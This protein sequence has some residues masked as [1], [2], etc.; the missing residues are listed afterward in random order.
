MSINVYEI[1]GFVYGCYKKGR[2]LWCYWCYVNSIC[3][4]RYIF[5]SWWCP[6]S[7]LGAA[8]K[9]CDV[10]L[11]S[12]KSMNR[13]FLD[14]LPWSCFFRAPSC[15]SSRDWIIE[16]ALKWINEDISDQRTSL[17]TDLW[18]LAAI[19][20]AFCRIFFYSLM[21]AAVPQHIGFIATVIAS[22]VSSTLQA[23][24]TQCHDPT[25]GDMCHSQIRM[26]FSHTATIYGR[27]RYIWT[28][29]KMASQKV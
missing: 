5:F 25:N 26:Q 24:A 9:T 4:S 7:L 28:K 19:I 29:S 1:P 20:I 10:K 8:K 15:Q 16:L 3:L 2:K 6:D 17:T 12:R 13:I 11:L 23:R 22:S 18:K 14:I 21:K 27:K